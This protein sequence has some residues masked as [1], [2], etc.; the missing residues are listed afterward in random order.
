MLNMFISLPRGWRYPRAMLPIILLAAAFASSSQ[1]LADS[2]VRSAL[3]QAA[4]RETSS[5][6]VRK[7][8]LELLKKPFQPDGGKKVLILGDS[9]AQDFT[10]MVFEGG[11]WQD[12]YQIRTRDIPTR[13]Q[14][15]LGEN[16]TKFIARQDQEFCEKA[17]SLEE[18]KPQI[19]EAD[20]IVLV[21]NW[22]EWSARELPTTI[23]HLNLTPQQKLFVVGRK[24][25]GKI[26][27]NNYL[28]MTE[29]ELRAL[30]NKPD[31]DQE[32]IN[33]ILKSSLDANAFVD[34]QPLVCE[35]PASCLVFTDDLKLISYDGGHLTQDGARYI[36]DL[37][38]QRT[39][40]GRY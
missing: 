26:S 4:D 37:L 21:A 36:G 35:A 29:E 23:S 25:F 11:H 9:H 5:Q 8:F 24:S 27:V 38:F 2:S 34:V 6:Y 30:R 16:A 31:S 18:A 22:K 14:P 32:K 17:D 33:G 19:A 20:I 40:L 10:N 1:S 28:R 3:M 15:A 7:R 39:S 13:C 12:G